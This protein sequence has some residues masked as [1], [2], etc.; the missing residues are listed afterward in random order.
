[1]S[2]GAVAVVQRILPAPPPVVFDEWLDVDGM[3][4]W[5][6]PRP[7]VPTLIEIEPRVGG[8]FH[9]GI[10]DEGMAV[11]VTGTYLAIER[12]SRLQFTWHCSI[13]GPSAP[14]SIVTVLLEP[15]GEDETLMTIHHAHLRPDLTEGHQHGWG[16]IADQ[17]RDD[18]GRGRRTG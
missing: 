7:A 3:K 17:L 6:C 11:T 12:P 4:E 8:R 14:V 18:L 15:H 2:A 16:R 1:M 5:M 13:W 9:L 10:D